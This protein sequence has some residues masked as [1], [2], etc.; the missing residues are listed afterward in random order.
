LL[1]R[2]AIFVAP[3]FLLPII[4][5]GPGYAQADVSTS[6]TLTQ[7]VQTALS[8]NVGLAQAQNQVQAATKVYNWQ[9]QITP[10]FVPSQN[11]PYVGQAPAQQEN[12]IASDYAL[13]NA[14]QLYNYDKNAL[15]LATMTDYFAVQDGQ[16]TV[17]VDTY[18]L[19]YQ[20][21]NLKDVTAEV[22]VGTATQQDLLA[23]Q[24]AVK[25]A[26]TQ[27]AA[28]QSSL[29]NAY[30][31]L[32][33]DLGID[34]NSKPDLT[35]YVQYQPDN[36][37]AGLGADSVVNM[38]VSAS[39]KIFA[40]RSNLYIANQT[41]GWNTT[42][43]LGAVQL[44]EAQNQLTSDTLSITQQA[45]QAYYALGS[46]EQA[47]ETAQ[48]NLEAANQAL[49]NAKAALAAGTI[50][51]TQYLQAVYQQAQ[52]Q[53]A[54]L[55]ALQGASAG[56][57]GASSSSGSTSSSSGA[58][59][60]GSASQGSSSSSAAG[61]GTGSSGVSLTGGGGSGYYLVRGE[62]AL[63]TGVGSILPPNLNGQ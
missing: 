33:N 15:V 23:A 11:N 36:T 27:L 1:K 41:W 14:S 3:L 47:Y 13:Q 34:P 48:Q 63:L 6:L 54:V 49:A 55:N 46:A 40:D 51:N 44:L 29:T 8:Q 17:A 39:P 45:Q 4:L 62:L 2:L 9:E 12:L 42:P 19:S 35:T 32:D 59:D 22:S 28:A 10:S 50:T 7:A 37:Y 57:G 56:S 60:S 30:T 53:L 16:Q 21:A 5:V 20:Q 18:D 25:Q 38:A 58:S 43:G 52:A 24:A 26:Q 61:G 31:A